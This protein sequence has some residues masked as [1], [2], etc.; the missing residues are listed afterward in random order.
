[1]IIDEAIRVKQNNAKRYSL[2]MTQEEVDAENLS[3][4][5]LGLIISL[6]RYGDPLMPGL[7]PGETED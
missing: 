3:I 7:L 2:F 1:M 6:R 4:E 5:A